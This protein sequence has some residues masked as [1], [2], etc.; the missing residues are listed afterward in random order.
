MNFSETK[1]LPPS[2]MIHVQLVGDTPEVWM[3]KKFK[4]HLSILD[5]KGSKIRGI[6]GAALREL[7]WVMVW[8]KVLL[9]ALENENPDDP[10]GWKLPATRIAYKWRKTLEQQKLNLPQWQ[11]LD[12]DEMNRTSLVIQHC[13]ETGRKLSRVEEILHF[14][15]ID[16]GA[17]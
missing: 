17:V 4:E 1:E 2:A 15:T 11:A 16:G 9:W 13:L 7:I 5:A 3:N 10:D 12:S 14:E 8:E 6:A